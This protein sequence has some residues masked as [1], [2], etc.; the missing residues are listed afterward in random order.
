MPYRTEGGRLKFL[1]REL[2]NETRIVDIEN[3]SANP[4]DDEMMKRIETHKDG[5]I[6]DCGAGRRD[7]CFENVLNYEIVGYDSTDVIGSASTYPLKA[8]RSTRCSPSPFWNMCAIPSD[9]R[10]RSRAF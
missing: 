7:I 5:L 6:L 2:R 9:A 1:T 10:R 3:V 4:F 8:I